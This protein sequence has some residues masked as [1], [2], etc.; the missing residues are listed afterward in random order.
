MIPPYQPVTSDYVI[1]ELRRKF[2]EKF[3]GHMT[4]L[5]GFLYNALSVIDV[6]RT[7]DETVEK[8]KVI[9]D[10]KDR[11]ILRA[12]LDAGAD[13]LLTGDKDFL[14]AAIDDPRIT[15]VAAFLEM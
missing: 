8:E 13:L 4:E 3:P 1:E 11:P 6:I 15:S 10:V 14:D 5:E 7:P 2:S 12:A 9:R